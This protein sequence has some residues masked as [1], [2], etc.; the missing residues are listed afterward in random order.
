MADKLDG[1]RRPSLPFQ[2]ILCAI[3]G[4]VVTV[5]VTRTLAPAIQEMIPGDLTLL[6]SEIFVGGVVVGASLPIIRHCF[7]K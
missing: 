4:G 3:L 5:V 1:K 7:A 2:I 6:G